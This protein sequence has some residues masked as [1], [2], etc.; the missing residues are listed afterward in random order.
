MKKINFDKD[1]LKL[2]KL[3]LM[4]SK[5]SNLSM[6]D[7]MQV[8]GGASEGGYQSCAIN[9]CGGGTLPATGTLAGCPTGS[10]MWT[11]CGTCNC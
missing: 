10:Y 7:M 11:V 6:Q 8:I 4:K 5:V 3:Q 2:K 9:A 1:G